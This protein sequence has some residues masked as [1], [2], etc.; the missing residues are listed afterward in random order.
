MPFLLQQWGIFVLSATD[1]TSISS[2]KS[3]KI[4]K[5]H[6]EILFEHGMIVTTLQHH[7]KRRKWK[8]GIFRDIKV[9][10]QGPYRKLPICS[11]T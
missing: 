10:E 3:S 4:S 2:F 9:S 7:L 1:I 5:Y 8:M 6:D 11:W